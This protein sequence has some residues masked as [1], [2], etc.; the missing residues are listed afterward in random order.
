MWQRSYSKTVYGLTPEQIW[1]V[2]SDVAHRSRWDDDTEWARANGPFVQGTVITMK[3][4][5]WSKAV[6]MEIVECTPY[7]SF[8]DYT[9]FPL[10]KLYGTHH[11]EK[12]GN[13]LKLTTTIKLVGPLSWL[14]RKLVA[15]EIVD[16]LPHQTDLLIKVASQPI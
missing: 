7:Q 1:Q 11:M 2:W 3:P 15:Q 14:W 10:A 13:G 9:K 12:D 8:T 5:G 4:K 16:T 6:T